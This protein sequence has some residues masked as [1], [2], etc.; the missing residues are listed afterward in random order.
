MYTDSRDISL[1]RGRQ[2]QKACIRTW[3]AH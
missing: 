2:R 3:S 1:E